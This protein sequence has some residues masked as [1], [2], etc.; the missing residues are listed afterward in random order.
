MKFGENLKK[1]RKSKNYSQDILAEKVGVSRQSV[2]KWETGDAYPEM[3]NILELCKIFKCK[4]N[5]LVNDSIIDLD[6]LD[7][8][9][10]MSVVKFKKEKQKKVKTLSKIISVLS[11]IGKVIIWLAIPL[12]ALVII[13]APSVVK[14]IDVKDNQITFK[15]TKV[16]LETKGTKLY[17]TY[18]NSK[19]G[20]ISQNEYNRL[21]EVFNNNSKNKLIFF[22][23]ASLISLEITLILL[24]FILKN[25]KKLS[26]NIHNQDTPF[27][28]ENV[29]HIKII[30][31]LMIASILIP[32]VSGTIFE[33]ILHA[34]LNIGM[35]MFDII[36]ILI[37]FTLSYVFEYGYEIQLDSKAKMYGDED[38][39]N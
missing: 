25:L 32:N 16:D 38:E 31:Y 6:S 35:E 2:S 28:L 24:S 20:D 11:E 22:V 34:D 37:I 17:I 15:D 27:T 39:Q 5:D 23:E 19:V 21:V 18:D 30:A 12:I 8:E 7:E 33:G 9:V 14:N 4:I 36:T 13:L 26:D 29:K 3:N 10:K 1:L